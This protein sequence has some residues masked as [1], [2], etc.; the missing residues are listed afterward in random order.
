MNITHQL[1][2][3][4]VLEFGDQGFHI[5][6]RLGLARNGPLQPMPGDR[7]SIGVIGTAET[8]EGFEQW[9]DQAQV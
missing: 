2:D 3:E 9:M 7:V 4:P 6:P 8:V 5:D 1:L